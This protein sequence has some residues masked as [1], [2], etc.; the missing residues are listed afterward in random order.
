MDVIVVQAAVLYILIKNRCSG[1]AFFSTSVFA[2]WRKSEE[3]GDC[4]DS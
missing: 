1:K 3:E 2:L 4:S